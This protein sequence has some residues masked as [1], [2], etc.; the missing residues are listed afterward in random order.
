MNSFASALL[1]G[2]LFYPPKPAPPPPPPPDPLAAEV[3]HFP[4]PF[5]V[6]SWIDFGTKHA[7]WIEDR[8]NGG[9]CVADA[10]LWRDYLM[11]VRYRTSLWKALR[12]VRDKA[13]WEQSRR[14]QLDWLKEERGPAAFANGWLPA[15]VE[16][17]MMRRMD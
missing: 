16:V 8:I 2:A 4:A 14:E 17:G 1:L 5:V 13:V 15:P 7:Q 12:D 9:L 10:A 11:E 6:D 3:A